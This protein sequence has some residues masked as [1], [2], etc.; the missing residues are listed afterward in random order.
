MCLPPHENFLHFFFVDKAAFVSWVT[1]MSAR[2]DYFVPPVPSA[3]FQYFEPVSVSYPLF[4]RVPQGFI[5]GPILFSLYMLHLWSI[6]LS[7]AM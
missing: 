5:L 1:S 3:V 6:Y 2:V 4:Y 7:M